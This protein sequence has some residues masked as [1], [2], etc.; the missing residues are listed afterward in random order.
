MAS[1]TLKGEESNSPVDDEQL[2]I[3]IPNPK[4]YMARQSLWTGHRGKPSV[5]EFFL[6]VITARGQREGNA[7]TRLYP[8]LLT[9]GFPGVIGCDRNLPICNHC[10]EQAEM[11]CNYTPKKRNK[12]SVDHTVALNG[13]EDASGGHHPFFVASRQPA[14]P[15]HSFYGQNVAS[16]SKNLEG[17]APPSPSASDS[18]LGELDIPR[19]HTGRFTAELAGSSTVKPLVPSVIS[20]TN[21]LPFISHSFSSEKAV[22]LNSSV[23]EPWNN[24]AFPPLPSFMNNRLRLM[25]SVEIP[26]R[27]AFTTALRGFLDNLIVE[28]R[29]TTCLSPDDYGRVA[30]C[31]QKGDQQEF[32]GPLKTWI[33][34]HRLCSGSDRYYLI[35]APKE[36][37]YS[38]SEAAYEKARKQYCQM[39]DNPTARTPEKREPNEVPFDRL[40]LQPQVYDILSYTH[41][42]HA[43]LPAMLKEI[44]ELGFSS[45]T[46]PIVEMYARL[47][48][49]CSIQHRHETYNAQRED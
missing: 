16:S 49:L 14:A 46:W 1:S 7:S 4:M 9:E 29:E 25:N 36:S 37:S 31:L 2:T 24:P 45:I 12:L 28:L 41:R 5:I 32:S 18:P 40:P 30:R 8:H 19:S 17:Q 42:S 21:S 22:I 35:L 38:L 34:N 44:T 33:K 39:I 6:P 27:D 48:P 11:D 26:S 10:S 15:A 13:P 20:R 3:R 47:C 23:V 43:P